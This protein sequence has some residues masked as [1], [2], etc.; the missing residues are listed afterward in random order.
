MR[1]D[2]TRVDLRSV[3]RRGLVAAL[4]VLGLA[5]AA[6]AATGEP[7]VSGTFVV[8]GKTIEL[9][10]AYVWAAEKGF[11]EE[12]DPTWT[13]LFVEHPVEPRELGHFVSDTAWI[14]LGVTRTEEFGDTPELQV[15]SQSLKLSADAGGNVTGGTYPKIELRS[16]GPDRF[17]GRV[18]HDEPQKIFDDTFQYDLTFDLP[19]SDPDAPIGEA[20]PADGGEPGRAY[21]RWVA[22]VHSGELAALKPLVPAEMAAALEGD[23]AQE[24][25]DFLRE[26][27]PTDVTILGGSSDGQ[28]ALLKIEGVLAGEK[29]QGE[30]T[31]TK[32][33]E[34]WVP[35]SSSW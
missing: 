15:Y 30:I 33:G 16:T 32:M 5:A 21:L 3:A 28:T 31:L 25:L 24:Q 7:E 8:N 6:G 18:H 4:L 27:T 1:E 26:L 11:Y 35:T 14:E 13:L 29:A 23:D 10:Y 19:L 20:L 17:V 12:S 2:R 34:L 9:P 22:A